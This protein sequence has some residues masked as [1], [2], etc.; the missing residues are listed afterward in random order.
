MMT[1]KEKKNLG[2]QIAIT[3]ISIGGIATLGYAIYF[4]FDLIKKWY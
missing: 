3:F 1:E 2:N 4:I